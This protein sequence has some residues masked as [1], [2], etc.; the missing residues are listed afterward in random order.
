MTRRLTSIATIAILVL[1]TIFSVAQAEQKTF[2]WVSHGSP[3]DPV[4]TYF[5]SGAQAWAED[6]G[7]KVNTS[8]HS[9]DVSSQQA[10][11]RSAI[12]AHA[13]GIV[14]TSP[15]PR[16]MIDVVKAAH[17]ANIPIININ[18]P[19]PKA[20]FDA[21]VGADN[22]ELGRKWAQY[23]VDHELVKS[24]D[25]V[26]MPVEVPGATYAARETKGIDSVFKP[27]GIDYEVT[28]T[29]L[30][31]AQIIAKMTY[32]LSAHQDK[33]DAIIGLGDLVMGSMQRVFDRAGV[34]PG[35]IPVVGWGNTPTTAQEVLD[36]YVNAAASQEPAATSYIGLSIAAMEASGIDANFD[37]HT[38]SLYEKE[39]AQRFLDKH[40]K[41]D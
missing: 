1:G 5:L 36:G 10:A 25:F 3:A 17:K 15:A 18:T 8:F 12:A 28:G 22:V 39:G 33:I 37:V 35:D 9:G 13:D 38:G 20:D 19:A 11:V 40:F 2:Y 6:T 34:E 4:W 30:D 27:L 41:E 29:T 32:Y 23:L 14:T 24:G 21:Y 16:S 7:N 31:Q 26:W